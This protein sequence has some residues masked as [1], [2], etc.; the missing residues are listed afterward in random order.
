MNI[1][2]WLYDLPSQLDR[3][4]AG[5]RLILQGLNQMALSQKDIQDALS[6]ETVEVDKAL[7]LLSSQNQTIKDLTAQLAAAVAANDQAG[8]QATVDALTAETQ[9]V[10]AALA[11]VQTP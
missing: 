10:D 7:D 1:L 5:Q 4:E 8:M 11:A 6:A 9:K 3:L 2:S